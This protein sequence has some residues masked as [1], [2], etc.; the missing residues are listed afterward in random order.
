M[1]FNDIIATVIE[2]TILK[3]IAT[4]AVTASFF[5]GDSSKFYRSSGFA[6]NYIQQFLTDGIE[7]GT[8]ADVNQSGETFR[9]LAFR[10][11]LGGAPTPLLSLM[12]VGS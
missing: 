1:Y 2:P 12:G 5:F 6:V 8:A 11:G 10:T 7:I 9:I 4:G 3:L